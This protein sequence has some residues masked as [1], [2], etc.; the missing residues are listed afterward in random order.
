MLNTVRNVVVLGG[1]SAEALALFARFT[2]P[3]T[4]ARKSLIN[5]LI[6]ALKGAGVWSKLDCLYIQAAETEQAGQRNW[7]KDAH[8]LSPVAAPTFTTDRGYDFNGT[9]Q[10]LSTQYTPSTQAVNLTLNNA[11]AFVWCLDNVQG[12]GYALA[13]TGAAGLIGLIPRR[14]GS[15]DTY[16]AALNVST[17]TGTSVGVVADSRGLT[18]ME[19]ATA[20]L[21]T[22]YKN[23]AASVTHAIASAGLPNQPV[24][25]GARNNSG[26]ANSFDTRAQAAAGMGASLGADGSLALYNAVNAYLTAVGAA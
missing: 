13:A 18:H 25:L 12:D 4:E 3:P 16:L 23:G 24:Y 15:A 11:S 8:N 2:T 14:S 5:N 10:Y 26:T 9:T 22:V 21:T 6:T 1:Y 7:I 20:N 19:R 17:T